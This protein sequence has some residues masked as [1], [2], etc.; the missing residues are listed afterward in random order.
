MNTNN[1]LIHYLNSEVKVVRP[2]GNTILT[3]NSIS[4]NILQFNDGTL[5]DGYSNLNKILLYPLSCLT[6]T[7]IHEGVEE[8]PLVELAKI[9]GFIINDTIDYVI[10]GNKLNYHYRKFY[11]DCESFYFYGIDTKRFYLIDNQLLLFQ[12]LFSRRINIFP[13]TIN[14]IDPRTLGDKNP[15]LITSEK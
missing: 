9:E 1:N 12:Y 7:I 2:D 3:L 15:Y 6:E 5:G 10:E 13:D 4:G 11:Y 8:I 14:S